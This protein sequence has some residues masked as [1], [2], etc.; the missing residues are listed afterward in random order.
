MNEQVP[1]E[2]E[3]HEVI[4]ISR[5][6]TADG[7]VVGT[8]GNVSIRCGD[9]VAVTPSGVEYDELVTTD[10]PVVQLDGTPVHGTLKP[11]SELPM[12]LTAYDRHRAGAVVHTHSLYATALS[13]VRTEVPAVHY[14]LAEFGG[15][16]RVAEYATFGTARLAE[17]MSEALTDRGA[18]ILRNHGTVAVGG[19]L[20]HAYNR[21][22]Q[23]EWLC[24]LWLTARQVGEPAVLDE[25][26]LARSA[27]QYTT[28]GQTSVEP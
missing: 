5:R 15:S 16:V 26:E 22:R 21:V 20:I 18:C 25:D 11:T 27:E 7:L 19:T 2:A 9:L 17:N 1:L 6:M 28:Y 4:R 12:H 24:Q 8:A 10:V 23:L 14:Q 3:R 13:L